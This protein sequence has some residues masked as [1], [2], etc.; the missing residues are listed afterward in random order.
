MAHASTRAESAFD[1]TRVGPAQ[2]A[3]VVC[4]GP[5]RFHP[6]SGELARDGRLIAL[7]DK[8]SRLLST[9]LRR[10]GRVVR[11]EELRWVLWP[12]AVCVDYEHRLN[13]AIR[14]LRSVLDDS[15]LAARYIETVPRVGYRFIADVERALPRDSAPVSSITVGH[16]EELRKLRDCMWRAVNGERQCVFIEGEAGSG[17]SYLVDRFL[18]F[19]A[20]RVTLHLGEGFASECN[21]AED[22]YGPLLEA[23]AT[24]ART[25]P[26]ALPL[27]GHYAPA[28][29]TAFRVQRLKH[30]RSDRMEHCGASELHRQL[31][32]VLEAAAE[33]LPVVLVLEDL[34]WADARTLDAIGAIARR[35]CQARL[36]II[37]THRSIALDGCRALRRLKQFLRARGQSVEMTLDGAAH[38]AAD[39]HSRAGRRRNRFDARLREALRSEIAAS[40]G[41]AAD[42]K[43]ISQRRS[44][45][46]GRV[47]AGRVAEELKN[48]R[49]SDRVSG[50]SPSTFPTARSQLE[51]LALVSAQLALRMIGQVLRA[52]RTVTEQ[53][54]EKLSEQGVLIERS[55]AYRAAEAVMESLLGGLS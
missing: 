22:A 24:L 19:A 5:F 51:L 44:F 30:A 16:E 35:R 14:R 40:P 23:L 26:A 42:G 32:S 10:P 36:L 38:A 8:P 18:R 4:F 34:Q 41:R 1:F 27:L 20:D 37:C 11:R 49:R 6:D 7:Q 13:T 47:S 29:L 43:A 54:L 52:D 15:H 17:K 50:A 21:V 45:P 31:V 55:A 12:D 28:W 33:Q 53:V 25:R 3:A 9:L 39:G 2:P 48:D 46:P